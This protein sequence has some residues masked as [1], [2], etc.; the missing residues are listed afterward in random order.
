MPR[1]T[2]ASGRRHVRM[3]DVAHAASVSVATV[4]RVINN[5]PRTRPDV[6]ERVLAAIE[7][8]N[9]RPN[10]NAQTLRGRTSTL[11]GVIVPDIAN[12]YFMAL[13]RG[14]EDV[15][16]TAGLSVIVA[17]TD[18]NP[19]KERRQIETLVDH[20]VRRIVLAPVR[21]DPALVDLFGD[22]SVQ[23]VLVDRDIPA[24]PFD[25]VRNNDLEAVRGLIDVLLGWGHR[26]IAIIAGPQTSFTGRV[27]LEAARAIMR[28]HGLDLADSRVVVG[29]FMDGHGYAGVLNLLQ[30][31]PAPTAVLACSNIILESVI[32]AARLLRL[33]IPAGVSVVGI[34]DRSL[35]D[36]IDP[37]ITVAQQ[38]PQT[39]G[40]L[41]MQLMLD[42]AAAAGTEEGRRRVLVPAP[43]I[44]GASVG[45]VP[46]AAV[47]GPRAEEAAQTKT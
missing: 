7:R 37:P 13:V 8:L 22:R 32:R 39:M 33:P 5:D 4:S 16:Q 31:R 40:H 34:A 2:P 21:E 9:Y 30:L 19:Q 23:C 42:A 28:E 3:E 15:A 26:D 14:C 24:A 35:M 38:D 17:S 41:A 45:G 20:G 44:P 27:R 12:P 46:V 11:V 47:A 18:E 6:R 43:L 1:D 25:L 29:D 36:L 10:R